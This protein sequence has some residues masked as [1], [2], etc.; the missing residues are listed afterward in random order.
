[1]ENMIKKPINLKVMTGIFGGMVILT[2][3]ALTSGGMMLRSI[4]FWGWVIYL[5]LHASSKCWINKVSL[6]DSRK[7]IYISIVVAFIIMSMLCIV[8]MG[9]IPCFNG[10]IPDHRNQYELMAESILDGH[11]YIEYDVDPRLLEMENPYDPVLRD[12]L[13][14]EYHWDHAFYN[15]HYYMYFGIV[16]VLILFLPYRLFTGLPLTTYHATQVF[17]ILFILGMFVLTYELAVRRN[18]KMTLGCYLFSVSALCIVSVNNIIE[19]PALYNTAVSSGICFSVWSIYF[20]L[21]AFDFFVTDEIN[22][23]YLVAAAFFGALVFGCRPN[24]GLYNIVVIPVFYWICIKLKNETGKM[25]STMMY[26]VVPYLIVGLLLML[27][28][29]V[30]FDSVFEFGQSYQLTIA[31]QHSYM[32]FS[33]LLNISEIVDSFMAI[34]L[35]YY[36]LQN[37]FPYIS[38]NGIL[39]CYPVLW[40]F[41]PMIIMCW[42]DRRSYDMKAYQFAVVILLSVLLIIFSTIMMSPIPTLERYKGDEYFLICIVMYMMLLEFTKRSERASKIMIFLSVM[43]YLVAFLLYFAGESYIQFYYPNTVELC[44]KVIWPF[45]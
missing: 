40:L 23:K 41:A 20:Y 18:R 35:G 12:Q 42:R 3:I 10:E 11:L 37:Y 43:T 36:G 7:T 1:M 24:I 32:Q 17:T 26:V 6:T 14:V 5:F 28:N 25:I 33:K 9:Y 34:F 30:R 39:L 15:G 13:D 19:A 21:K 4:T 8:P 2:T 27:Y 44:G 16:P 22:S 29:Y 38:Y 31:D 45:G